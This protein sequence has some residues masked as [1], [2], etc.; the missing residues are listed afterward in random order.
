MQLE[1]IMCQ[2]IYCIRDLV[3]KIEKAFLFI[4]VIK[5]SVKHLGLLHLYK[6][7]ESMEM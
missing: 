1:T 3:L 6:K 4:W 2:K 5:K 7:M